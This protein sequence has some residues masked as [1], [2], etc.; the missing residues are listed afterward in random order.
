[1]KYL[2]ITILSMVFLFSICFA[3]EK[4]ELK[5]Q[6]DKESYSLG[7]QFGQSLKAQGL[8]VNVDLYI[9]GVRDFLG[10][11]EPMMTQEEIRVTIS[12]LQKRLMADRQKELKEMAEKNL[13]QSKVFLE[14]NKKKEG[15]KTLV[16]GLQY[17][18][19]LEGSG[20]I[21]KATDT[22]TVHYRGTFIEGSEFDN[23]YKRGQPATFQVN[24]VIP[25]W[26]EALQL[27]KEGSKWQLFVPPELGYG[28]RGTG[29]IPPNSTLIFE[30]ELISVG[31]AK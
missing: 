21:P 31:A 2:F 18:I 20:K 10:G 22:V 23:S 14:E 12:E 16:S 13:A 7:Y 27:M 29:P 30:V 4:L 5:D 19:L 11:K 26:A 24:V 15:I 1:M 6:K 17:K 25:G 3:A 8:D 9:S 28:E